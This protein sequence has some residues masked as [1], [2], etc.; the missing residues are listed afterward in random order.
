MN[1]CSKTKECQCDDCY[2]LPEPRAR[3]WAAKKRGQTFNQIIRDYNAGRETFLDRCEPH[4]D[5]AD[6]SKIPWKGNPMDEPTPEIV[7]DVGSEDLFELLFGEVDPEQFDSE[8]TT[9]LD[10]VSSEEALT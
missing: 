7:Y 10:Q 5:Y 9:L 1:E 6:V 2:F 4:E 8:T 3:L